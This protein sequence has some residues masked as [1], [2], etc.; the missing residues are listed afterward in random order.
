MGVVHCNDSASLFRKRCPV[1]GR[2]FDC[3]R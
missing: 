3:Q 1:I 2:C